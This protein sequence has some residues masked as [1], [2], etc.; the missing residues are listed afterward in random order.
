MI[1]PLYFLSDYFWI[2]LYG[3]SFLQSLPATCPNPAAE[4]SIPNDCGFY[5][6]CLEATFNCGE[7]GYPIGYGYKYC[8]RFLE[9][10]HRFSKD[11]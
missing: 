1:N 10:K 4:A 3:E 7:K 6:D 2:P 8:N 11:G 5:K 9:E